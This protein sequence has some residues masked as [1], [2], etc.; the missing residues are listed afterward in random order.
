MKKQTIKCIVAS[1]A[2]ISAESCVPAK[3]S[4]NI[5][6]AASKISSLHKDCGCEDDK[7][8]HKK[9]EKEDSEKDKCKTENKKSES[10]EKKDSC[11]KSYDKT[12][13]FS[14]DTEKYLTKDQCKHWKE[15]KSCNDKGD[16]LTKEQEDFLNTVMDCVIKGKLGDKNY[17]EYKEIMLKKEKGETLCSE[18]TKKLK[19]FND[20]ISSSKPTVHE[21]LHDFLR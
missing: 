16:K 6:S 4:V 7:T 21:F 14:K 1:L 19:E 5:S 9:K 10:T 20:M 11:K 18:D 8:S 17:K 13:V 12:I 2:I 15:V 3:A